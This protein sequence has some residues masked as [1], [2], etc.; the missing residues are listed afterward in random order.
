MI[1]NSDQIKHSCHCNGCLNCHI[2]TQRSPLWQQHRRVFSHANG[3]KCAECHPEIDFP[4]HLAPVV[5]IRP[6][7]RRRIVGLREAGWT[8]R[9]TA[10]L[11]GH[12]VCRCFQQ[13][14]VGHFH[15]R[16]PGSVRPRGT[17]ARQDGSIV[18][19]AVA[20]STAS[21]EE[22]RAHVSPAVSPRIIGNHLLAAGNTLRVP[23][24]RISLIP[25]HRQAQLP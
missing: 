2:N 18:R 10:A 12:N 6:F 4:M 20:A 19:A 16:R 25:R 3:H 11:V 15:T 8:C 23:L 21:R 5:A 9:R 7:E 24:A 1:T 13:W 14:S 22:I 17:D